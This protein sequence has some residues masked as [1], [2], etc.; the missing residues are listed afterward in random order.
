MLLLKLGVVG[1]ILNVA[2]GEHA[3][4]F[5]VRQLREDFLNANMQW[6]R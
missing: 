1:I 4:S 6:V 2:N 3:E 5:T